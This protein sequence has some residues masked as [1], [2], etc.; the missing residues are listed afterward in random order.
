MKGT[1]SFR[2]PLTA[3]ATLCLIVLITIPYLPGLTGPF[4]FDDHWNL[5][6]TKIDTLSFES[7]R[8]VATGNESGMLGRP[9]PTLTFALN[10]YFG[11]NAS[12]FA[13]KATNL[14]IH[15]FN[16]VLLWWVTSLLCAVGGGVLEKRRKTVGWIAAG[17]WALHPLHVSAV[18]YAVQRM[19]LLM[20]TFV[21]LTL[22]A[23]LVA[24]RNQSREGKLVLPWIVLS[25]PFSLGAVLSKEN[26]ALLPLYVIALE[27]FVLCRL[28]PSRPRYRGFRLASLGACIA[29]TFAVIAALALRTEV[30]VDGYAMREF[31]MLQRVFAQLDAM[32]L[33][34][35]WLIFPTPSTMTFYHDGFPVPDRFGTEQVVGAAL[36]LAMVGASIALRRRAPLVGFGLAFFL[37]AHVMESSIIPLELVFEHRNYLPSAGLAIAFA[38]GGTALL[39][40]RMELGRVGAI[41]CA[42]L[43]LMFAAMT[44][45]RA[46]LWSDRL[47]IS[48]Q[49]VAAQPQSERGWIELADVYASLGLVE[50]AWQTY[51]QA[52]EH[53]PN[54]PHLELQ[55]LRIAWTRQIDEPRFHARAVQSLRENSFDTPS[56]ISLGFLAANRAER[57]DPVPSLKQLRALFDAAGPI[58]SLPIPDELKVTLLFQD[59]RLLLESGDLERARQTINQLAALS[60][61]SGEVLM[62][63]AETLAMVGDADGSQVA[64]EAALAYADES[65]TGVRA[66]IQRV[67]SEIA[68]LKD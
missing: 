66:R 5:Q 42:A 39:A 51:E 37:L 15:A 60:P 41:A 59:H 54:S 18:L 23:Y 7:L 2:H 64:L 61:S 27:V 57:R 33:Y 36:L 58:D 65:D 46:H 3:A 48:H 9:V 28:P 26:G 47:S 14:A 56:G 55:R 29:V 17:I 25:V 30:F 44:A 45:D 50:E 38:A 34:L 8:E 43:L 67:V 12:S 52:F 10:W 40:T 20:A 49:A 35:Q 4:I 31:D 63:Q 16:A 11:D 13:F 22:I 62:R 19:T 6:P 68:Q 21:L 53:L 32:T 24:R 1:R